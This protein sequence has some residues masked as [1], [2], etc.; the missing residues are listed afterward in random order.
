[1]SRMYLFFF[2]HIYLHHWFF[3]VFSFL[4]DCMSIG[5]KCGK[6]SIFFSHY[7]WKKLTWYFWIFGMIDN[8]CINHISLMIFKH[9][10]LR[11]LP[12]IYHYNRR[13][14]YMKPCNQERILIHCFINKNKGISGYK[15]YPYFENLDFL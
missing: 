1:M 6:G 12:G 8:W 10:L 5:K 7:E 15:L 11:N 13:W 3:C 2:L 9:T 4:C 14:I